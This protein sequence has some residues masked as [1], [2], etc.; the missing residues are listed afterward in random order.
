MF[1]VCSVTRRKPVALFNIRDFHPRHRLALTTDNA[2]SVLGKELEPCDRLLRQTSKGISASRFLILDQS[3]RVRGIYHP[4][5]CLPYPLDDNDALG[6]SVESF[7]E[8]ANVRQRSTESSSLVL[9]S[10]ANGLGVATY[11]AR[12]NVVLGLKNLTLPAQ[13]METASRMSDRDMRPFVETTGIIE[14]FAG[15]VKEH[16]AD[17]MHSCCNFYFVYNDNAAIT[18]RGVA[19]AWGKRGYTDKMPLSFEDR[20]WVPLPEAAVKS[21]DRGVSP[22]YVDADGRRVVNRAWL[23]VAVCRGRLELDD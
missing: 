6:L 17:C 11:D 23:N 14:D 16:Y 18:L 12:G 22:Y 4:P 9:I 21:A 7:L 15:I 5:L 3:N 1:R 20:R 19:V 10:H 8:F 2:L 13:R